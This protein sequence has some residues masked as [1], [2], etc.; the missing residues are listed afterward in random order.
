MTTAASLRPIARQASRHETLEHRSD[1]RRCSARA[2]QHPHPPKSSR[3]GVPDCRRGS[4]DFFRE[5]SGF[6][7]GAAGVTARKPAKAAKSTAAQ[8]KSEAQKGSKSVARGAISVP[9]RRKAAAKRWKPTAGDALRASLAQ[10]KDT[11][12]IKLLVEQACRV[13]NRLEQLDRAIKGDIG[14]ILHLDLGR[15]IAEETPAGDRKAFYVEVTM[16]VDAAV[17]EERQQSKLFASLLSDIARQRALLPPAPPENGSTTRGN[18]D[19]D[20]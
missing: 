16:K 8:A 15:I 1:L 12:G 6:F 10:E 4:Q 19:L 9:D 17:S 2:A 20:F 3:G 14:T 5:A 18:G 7:A 11:G 13:A